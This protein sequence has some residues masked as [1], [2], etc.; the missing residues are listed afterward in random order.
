M[1]FDIII[2]GSG[3]GGYTLAK[4]LRRVNAQNSI[5]LISADDGCYYSKP[6]LST[7]FAKHKPASALVAKSAN[8]MAE[9]LNLS[10]YASTQVLSIDSIKQTVAIENS[11]EMVEYKQALVL[12]TGAEPINIPLPKALDGRC[13]A[14]NDLADY[15]RFRE[16]LGGQKNITIIGSGLVGCEYANDMKAAGLNVN[17]VALDD[18]PLQLLLPDEL[19]L[20]V[21]QQLA[22]LGIN[23]YFNNSIKDATTNENEQLV[24]TLSSGDPLICDLVL[25]AVGLKPRLALAQSAGCQT[26]RGIIVDKTLQ[27]TTPNIYALGDCAEIDGNVMMYVAPLTL[28]AKALA[29]TLNG[30][31]TEVSI[32]A[33]PV[34]VKTPG[35]PVVANPPAADSQGQWQIEGESPDLKAT[36]TA[37][38][39][40]LLGFALTGKKVIER[41]KLAKQLPAIV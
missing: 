3:L 30:E 20:A 21:Q 38:D 39:G 31:P 19:S 11:L 28:C 36:F 24:L 10:V 6:L 12:A 9:E 1:T 15:G 40:R 25:S 17:V 14:I 16:Q 41:M 22:E 29:K 34:I 8:Q 33:S 5:L 37:K 4:E 26:N 13:M 23:W 27:T 18:S 32:P 35:C 2:I 7:G